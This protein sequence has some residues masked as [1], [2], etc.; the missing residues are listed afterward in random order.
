M[1]V[2]HG[3]WKKLS[4][5]HGGVPSATGTIPISTEAL[6]GSDSSRSRTSEDLL[7]DA[8]SE[9]KVICARQDERFFHLVREYVSPVP[10]LL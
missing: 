9:E 4:N 7:R 2:I 3:L 5:L 1:R 8:G 6:A 10:F